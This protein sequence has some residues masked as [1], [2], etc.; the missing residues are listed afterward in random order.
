[1]VSFG[2]SKLLVWWQKGV[3]SAKICCSYFWHIY[4]FCNKEQTEH[5]Q[6]YKVTL[7]YSSVFCNSTGEDQF[8]KTQQ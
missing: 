7:S 8:I 1:M 6:E 2:G 3:Q 4:Q 5:Q